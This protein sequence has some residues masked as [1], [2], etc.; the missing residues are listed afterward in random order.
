MVATIEQIQ[1]HKLLC[2]LLLL[3]SIP[4]Y[5]VTR[6]LIVPPYGRH[7]PKQHQQQQQHGNQHGNQQEQQQINKT[8]NKDLLSNNTNYRWWYGPKFN[9]RISWCL[10]EIP[11]LIWAFYCWMYWCDDTIFYLNLD[12]SSTSPLI[13]TMTTIEGNI[14]NNNNNNIPQIGILSTNAILLSL[15]ALHYIHRAI[16]Y[17]LRMNSNATKVPL[18]TS[19]AGFLITAWNG[20]L[21]CFYLVQ[22]EQRFA[23]TSFDLLTLENV[24]TWVGILVFFLGMGMNIHSDGVLRNLRRYGPITNTGKI[25]SNHKLQQTPPTTTSKSTSNHAYHIPHSPFFTCISCPNLSGEILEWF[26]YALASRFSLPSVAF[27]VYTASNLIPRGMAHHEWYLR[28]FDDYPVARR[29]A[30][31]PFVV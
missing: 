17:P 3:I 23:P 4:T 15:F 10:F 2:H 24:Q 6:Y 11:N 12:S 13:S 25:N 19:A 21:Q 26:G 22:I 9:A 31:I 5:I 18:I 14:N 29:W 8:K 1:L 30:L 20:Y 28:K 27:F 7:V 16:L